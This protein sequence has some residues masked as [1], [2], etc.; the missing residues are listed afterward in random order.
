MAF[1]E[2]HQGICRELASVLTG[3]AV[4][5]FVLLFG[6]CPDWLPLKQWE[7][8]ASILTMND[9]AEERHRVN[10]SEVLPSYYQRLKSPK[11]QY[12][13]KNFDKKSNFDQFNSDVASVSSRNF[14]VD[15]G[16]DEAYCAFDLSPQCIEELVNSEVWFNVKEEIWHLDSFS[17]QLRFRLLILEIIAPR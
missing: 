7:F 12:S 10:D 9:V 2:P 3:C 16:D 5:S 14:L 6:Q 17:L 4:I 13:I 11:I 1:E 15:Y 8:T